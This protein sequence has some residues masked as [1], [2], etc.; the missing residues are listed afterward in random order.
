VKRLPIGYSD[1][2][3]IID[4]D[5][6]Y[7]DKTLLIKEIVLYGGA[8]TLIPRPRRFGK[9]L[10]LSMLHY[11]F[12]KTEES[13][14]Y[15]FEDKKIW[16][17]SAMRDLQ[18]QFPVI[19]LSLKSA[20][21]AQ[22]QETY[23][24]IKL[25]IATEFQ[26][27]RYLL[28]QNHLNQDDANI[29]QR[30]INRSASDA[31]YRASLL[32]LSRFLHNYHKKKVILLVDEYDTPLHDAIVNGY[33]NE[34]ITFMRS[35]LGDALKD[36][37]YIERGIITGILRTAKEGIFSG[38]NNLTVFS[39]LS[40]Q[41]ADSFGFT[42]EEIDQLLHDYN[43]TTIS[44]DFKT[45]YN[46][47]NIGTYKIYNP[48]S[49]LECVSNKGTFKP[50][51]VNTSENTLISTIIATSK[52]QIQD[53]CGELIK[54]NSLP[55]IHIEEKMTLPG[56]LQ[57][58]NAIWSLLLFSGYVTP[59]VITLDD[60]GNTLCTLT[61]PNR[62]LLSLFNNI[63]ISLFNKG[64]E[65]NNIRYL[66]TALIEKDGETLEKLIAK[67]I[68]HSMSY[69]DISENEPE[70]SY[71]LFVLGL[72]MI[73]SDIYSVQSNRESGYGRFDIMLIPHNK[74]LPSI[75]IEFKKED[76]KETMEECADRALKQVKDKKYVAELHNRGITNIA[77]FGI[78]CYKK[79]IL[80]KQ[81]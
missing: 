39:V 13:N 26:R 1:Y 34:A 49:S 37:K 4:N 36:N 73:C 22:W 81:E 44:D 79:E 43:L 75:I 77:F 63:I 50:Y 74:T 57:D 66:K 8:V 55:N 14:T 69:H 21:I 16:Q 58:E 48:W 29:F 30:I 72:F 68:E 9:T 80:L 33:Y 28:D 47:Y 71:H 40:K 27:H 56:M 61:L 10:N 62:E 15:L 60:L 59:I 3:H 51:W 65:Q 41:C 6:Y 64:L 70:K 46:G 45:W 12:E 31:D 24:T 20:R 42:Q 5:F 19:F 32:H 35:F 18:G 67:F 38:L 53:A 11:F 25:V 52:V 23:E 76:K 7:L 2:K 54:G 78:A 17:D